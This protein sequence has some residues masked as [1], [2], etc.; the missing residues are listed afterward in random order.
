MEVT[1]WTQI[2]DNG[3]TA[4]VTAEMQCTEGSDLMYCALSLEIFNVAE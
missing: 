1:Q 4:T 3:E 2:R